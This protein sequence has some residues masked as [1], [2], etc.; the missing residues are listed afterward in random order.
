MILSEVKEALN[1]I[2]ELNFVLPDGSVVPSHFHI[3]EVGQADKHYIDC[4]GTVRQESKIMF[5]LFTAD[6]IDHR[7]QAKKL[8]DIIHISEKHLKLKDAEVEVE[9]QGDT[10][11]T[12]SLAF[13]G[14]RFQLENKF[15]DC[16]AKDKCGI[17]DKPKKRIR[18][19]DLSAANDCVPGGGC[20]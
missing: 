11:G 18:L 17:P 15:T 3:T 20:C 4:G 9:Y 2:S 7:L 14:Q 1:Q 6:D 19:G 5:Q 16:L 12:Y 10:I 8:A 13:D